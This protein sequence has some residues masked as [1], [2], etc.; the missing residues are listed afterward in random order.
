MDNRHRKIGIR[1]IIDGRRGGIRESLEGMT[2]E[3]ARRVAALY[4]DRLRYSDGTPVECVIADTTIGGVKEAAMA[5][6][7]FADNNVGAVL[8]VTP[9]WCYG[10]ETI[11]M[12]PLM[13][14]AIWGFNKT[15]RPGAVYLASALAGHNQKGLPAF[16]IYGCDV[17]DVDDNSITP[18][19]EEKL[20]RF[21][22]AA[23]AVMEMRGMSYLS[24]GSVS[25]GIAGSI[26]D[27]DFFQEYLGMRNE[28]V[29]CSEIARRIELGIYDK[30][31]FARAMDWVNRYCKQQE[32]EDLNPE[33]LRYSREKK[34]EVW[35]YVVKM[36]IIF[37]DLMV[38]NPKLA[39]MG[40]VEESM[41]HNAIAGGFQGQRQWTDFRPD[42]DFSEAILNSSFDWNGIRE[43]FVFATENDTLNGVSMLFMHLLTNQAQLFSDVR[44]Y[45]S[46]EAV[47]RATGME[48]KG[49]AANGVIHLINSGSSTLDATGAM[50]DGDGNPVMK[51]FWKI[52][53]ADSEACLAATKWHPAGR[54]YMRG[55][56]FSSKFLTRGDMP[57]TMCRV[58][59]V[60][61]EGPVLQIA[62]GWAVNV[63]R[64][65]YEHIDKRTDP[66]W[67][68]TWFAPR[69]TG[70]G[71]FRSVYSVMNNWGANHGAITFGHIGADLITLA[72]MLRIPVCMHNVDEEKIFRPS[73]WAAF[74]MDAEGS[75]YRACRNYGALYR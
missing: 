6:E 44:T 49:R 16:G 31:E 26:P 33:H 57:V 39:E 65:I 5:A 64:E 17:Q 30:E 7:K 46:P 37:R 40:F 9:C 22:R 50:C 71:A 10:A 8:S 70:K 11:D 28:Y 58:N 54:E 13:P 4:A 42:G 56:G 73:A 74:G 18:D 72:S 60:K 36:T 20:L 15:Q 68:T 43:P 12:D 21:G 41:G 27:P 53:E 66:S 59:L 29:D 24:I 14:K 67:P 1:P 62:E 75:D 2:M 55:G 23:V 69:L 45:W 38:G 32:G 35:E 3:M 25:M 48:L 61:G 52:T 63:D 34:D 19:V 51:P 47:K